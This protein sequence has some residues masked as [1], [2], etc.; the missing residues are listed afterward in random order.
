M[1]EGEENLFNYKK[2]LKYIHFR[3]TCVF[4]LAYLH[5]ILIKRVNRNYNQFLKTIQEENTRQFVLHN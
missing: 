2:S 3:R 4:A 5:L 1:K